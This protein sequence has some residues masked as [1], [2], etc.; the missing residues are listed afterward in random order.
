M[1]TYLARAQGGR[2]EHRIEEAS[3]RSHRP[4]TLCGKDASLMH[5]YPR[6]TV[7]N[8]ADRVV[9]PTCKDCQR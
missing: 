9:R 7:S 3:A 6:P 2:I 1:T 8:S 4:T 5:R